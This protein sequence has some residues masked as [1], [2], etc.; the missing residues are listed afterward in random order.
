MAKFEVVIADDK[1]RVMVNGFCEMERSKVDYVVVMC[2]LDSLVEMG[3]ISP[4]RRDKECAI[5]KSQRID[6]SNKSA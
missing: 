3:L 2:F 5:L 6:T 1:I 4:S